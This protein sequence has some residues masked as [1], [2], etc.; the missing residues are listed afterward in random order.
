MV[1]NK[2][3]GEMRT[4]ILLFFIPIPMEIGIQRGNVFQNPSAEGF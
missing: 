4:Q 1:Q 3:T 2:H